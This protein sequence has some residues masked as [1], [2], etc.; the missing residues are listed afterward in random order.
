[1]RGD[2]TKNLITICAVLAAEWKLN[3]LK[4]FVMPVVLIFAVLVLVVFTVVNVSLKT[5]N[6]SVNLVET[7]KASKYVGD[8]IKNW[9]FPKV[10]GFNLF[11]FPA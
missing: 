8:I 7:E 9:L 2:K 10:S 4:K 1:M 11:P 6:E 3:M 5:N